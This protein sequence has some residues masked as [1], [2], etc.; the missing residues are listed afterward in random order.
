MK[1]KAKIDCIN[2]Y[3]EPR[4]VDRPMT[5]A[6]RKEYRREHPRATEDDFFVTEKQPRFYCKAGDELTIIS[7]NPCAWQIALVVENSTGERFVMRW[8]EMDVL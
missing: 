2:K 3:A 4:K 7:Q 6:E 5:A 8:D 1:A